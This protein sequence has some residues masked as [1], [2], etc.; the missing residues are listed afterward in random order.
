MTYETRWEF[1]DPRVEGRRVLEVGPAEL[2]GTTASHKGDRWIHGRVA[3]VAK[4]LVGVEYSQEQVDALRARGFDI[5]QG[6]A[7]DFNVEGDFDVVLAGELIEHLSNPGLFLDCAYRHLLPGGKI[8][9]TTPNRF[10]IDRILRVLR[11]GEIP[12][13]QK[14]IAKHVMYFDS[15]S[16]GS[17]LERHGFIDIEIDYCMWVGLPRTGGTKLAMQL[18]RRFRPVMLSTIVAT[19]VKKH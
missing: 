16:L 9:L 18:A 2:V 6:D 17:L 13:Y 15:D 7:Q 4:S 12:R 1:I 3:K 11:T 10:A 5:E 8:V 19:A 14:N